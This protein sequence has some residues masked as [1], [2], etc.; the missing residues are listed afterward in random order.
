MKIALFILITWL[1]LAVPPG[2]HTATDVPSISPEQALKDLTQGNIRYSSQ[3]PAHPNQ[4]QPRRTETAKG[5]HPF[6]VIVGCSDSRVPPEIIFDQGIGDLF[7]IR[8]AGNVVDDVGLGSIEYAVEHLHVPLI[9]VLGH[10]KCGAVDATV[11]GGDPGGHIRSLVDAIKPAVEQVKG[12]PGD[13]L[14]NAVRSQVKMVVHQLK[15]SKP[16]LEER[17]LSGDLKIIGARYDLDDGVVT[18]LP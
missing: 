17:V 8:A 13:V 2:G 10:E 16:I 9:V 15:T 4:T 18:I 6:A 3:A 14:D 5:Q 7:V 1:L 11:K 12:Q